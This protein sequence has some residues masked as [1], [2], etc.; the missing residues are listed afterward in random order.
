LKEN[1]L[2]FVEMLPFF[3]G[4]IQK[5]KE[6]LSEPLLVLCSL[7]CH[8]FTLDLSFE[9][10]IRVSSGVFIWVSFRDSLIV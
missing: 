10:S 9:G 4:I 5:S 2:V 1:L 7:I 8:E 3:R 6:L